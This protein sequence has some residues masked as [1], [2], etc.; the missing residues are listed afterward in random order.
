MTLYNGTARPL[1]AMGESV[2]LEAVGDVVA[3]T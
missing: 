3:I 2:R 1:A